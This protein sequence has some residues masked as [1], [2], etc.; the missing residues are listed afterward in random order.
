MHQV[1]VAP[2]LHEALALIVHGVKDALPV[3]A[4][5]VYLTDAEN[6]QFVLMASDGLDAT[7]AGPVRVGGEGLVGLVAESLCSERVNCSMPLSLWRTALRF[8]DC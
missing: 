3:D 6:D 7:S 8:T 4:C 5:A 2:S 1:Q